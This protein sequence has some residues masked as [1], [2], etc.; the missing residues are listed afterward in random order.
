V[1]NILKDNRLC[2]Q[3]TEGMRMLKICN[4]TQWG[5]TYFVVQSDFSAV[6]SLA[7]C[8]TPAD[9]I[10]APPSKPAAV[11]RCLTTLN[12][13]SRSMFSIPDFQKA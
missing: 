8:Q 6:S 2:G 4:G 11:G 7:F 10:F 5:S 9:R 12:N 3:Q 1:L 13:S